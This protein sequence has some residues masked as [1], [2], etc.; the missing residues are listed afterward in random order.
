MDKTFDFF[1]LAL[2]KARGKAEEKPEGEFI[3]VSD[4]VSAAASVYE[5]IR[6]SLEYDEEHLLR[7]NAIRRILK[8]QLG[9]SDGFGLASVL[10][11]ELIWARYLPNGRVPESMVSTVGI[12][13]RKYEALF[14]ASKTVT[15]GQ[16]A[17]D[18]L[19]DLLASE[20][21]Y[22]LTPPIADEALAS[23]AYAK[24]KERLSWASTVIPESD[25]DLQLYIA[26]HRAVLKS[27]LATLRFRVFTLFHPDWTNT[28]A[29]EE[30]APRVA[31][32]LAAVIGQVERQIVHQGQDAL[33]LLV[34]RHSIVFHSIRDVAEKDPQRFGEMVAAHD[35]HELD[36]LLASSAGERYGRFRR[37]MRNSVV[38]AVLFLFITKMMLAL[39]IEAPYERLVL[40]TSDMR[41][42]I[43]NILFHPFLL[44][45]IGLS[46]RLPE[47]ANTD[48]VIRE[49]HA[50]LGIGEEIGFTFKMRRP[51][52]RGAL[53]VIFNVVYTAM[54][55]FTIGVISFVLHSFHFNWLSI[56]FFIFFLSLVTFF[57]LKIRNSRRELMVIDSKVS[58]IGTI[59]DI[60]FLP[61]IRAGRW[62]AL[63]APRI[64]V[65][66][67]FFDFIVEAP[68]KAAINL[69]EGWLAF[70]REKKEEI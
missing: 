59:G 25:R 35:T 64:N 40:K 16:R 37:R 23:F 31:E 53:G 32:N 48:A 45:V 41:P 1:L 13:I 65:F 67:F 50:F 12:I 21:E 7:R 46:A 11:R 38:R 42:L 14:G 18:W 66:L 39:I 2:E 28:G 34:R 55:L 9:E 15:E 70:L 47:S 26:I 43:V 36:G 29:N 52:S 63:R 62:V 68:F 5:T 17:Y 60:L 3:M 44:G 30:V 56:V 33:Y 24:L 51:W 61:M 20:I 57:G 54:F 8:R 58:F 49:A 22:A 19:L 10:L 69:V 4:T 27:N 6:N